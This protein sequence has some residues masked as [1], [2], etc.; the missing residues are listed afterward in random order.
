[1]WLVD[2]VRPVGEKGRRE[3]SNITIIESMLIT[4]NATDFNIE[5]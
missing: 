3:R 5:C 1:M 2:C 4:K